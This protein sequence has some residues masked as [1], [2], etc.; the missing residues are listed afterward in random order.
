MLNKNRGFQSPIQRLYIEFN[1]SI[2]MKKIILG[3]F[4]LMILAF[5]G[6]YF[7]LPYIKGEARL[8]ATREGRVIKDFMEEKIDFTDA[9]KQF[10]AWGNEALP[11]LINLS[12]KVEKPEQAEAISSMFSAI[13]TFECLEAYFKMYIKRHEIPV[14]EMSDDFNLSNQ[15][16]SNGLSA[17]KYQLAEKRKQFTESQLNRI[18]NLLIS[19]LDHHSEEIRGEC[20]YTLAEFKDPATVK[21]FIDYYHRNQKKDSYVYSGVPDILGDIGGNEAEKFLL[22][23]VNKNGDRL[24]DDAIDA[25][26]KTGTPLAIKTIIDGLINEPDQRKHLMW[27]SGLAISADSSCELPLLNIA[28]DVNHPY[29]E[30]AVQAL[31]NLKSEESLN[32]IIDFGMT[33]LDLNKVYTDLEDALEALIKRPDP[34]SIPFLK[35]VL[36]KEKIKVS[37]KEIANI[38]RYKSESEK[39]REIRKIQD[40]YDFSD[41]KKRDKALIALAKIGTPETLKIILKGYVDHPHL[42]PK[43]FRVS[44]FPLQF[45]DL[46]LIVEEVQTQV[47]EQEYPKGLAVALLLFNLLYLEDASTD[48][49]TLIKSLLQAPDCELFKYHSSNQAHFLTKFIVAE[50]ENALLFIPYLPKSPYGW[51]RNFWSTVRLEKIPEEVKSKIEKKLPFNTHPK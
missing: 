17:V 4:T 12:I 24:D 47:Q 29:R 1:I 44:D 21:I 27:L 26:A 46:K 39:K 14:R 48:Y 37:H 30:Y 9:Y 15:H 2:S 8:S 36:E 3:I 33:E 50:P 31:G 7:L 41:Q 40:R 20:L 5:V 22:D 38:S 16:F 35:A 10:S 23:L 6:L 25:L 32:T 34:R 11:N 42:N 28:K 13:Q 49:L 51:A 45:I 43:D 19:G 18:K